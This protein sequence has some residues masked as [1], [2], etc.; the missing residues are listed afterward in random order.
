MLAWALRSA[1]INAN[2]LERKEREHTWRFVLW[3]TA[4]S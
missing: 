3:E 1:V 4:S 2:R